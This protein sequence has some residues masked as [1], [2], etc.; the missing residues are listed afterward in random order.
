MNVDITPTQGFPHMYDYI[1]DTVARGANPLVLVIFVAVIIL[2]YLLF[3]YIGVKGRGASGT[4]RA[5]GAPGITF[6]E[7]VMWGLFNFL[8]LING[9]QYFFKI[10]IK[11]GIRNLFTAVPEID[12]TVTTPPEEAGEEMEIVPEIMAEHQVFHVTDN[13]YTYNDAKALCKAYGGRLANY[14]EI[15]KAYKSGAEWCGY[16][17]S[18]DQMA[19][20]PTQQ[21]TWETLQ[22]IKGH[23][24]DCGRPGINGGFIGN[25]HANY[26]ANCYGYKPKITRLESEI[27]ERTTPIPM[28]PAEEQFDKKVGYYRKQLPDI[29]VSPFNYTQWSQI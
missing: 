11:T 24:H 8:V 4:S 3:S 6:I 27:M 19:L 5:V 7:I 29:L 14:D 28:T 25:K 18:A 16:G 20:Y 23:E 17:W 26:G 10:D 21:K 9:L 1:G 22:K 12:V 13:G 15:E 2:Y